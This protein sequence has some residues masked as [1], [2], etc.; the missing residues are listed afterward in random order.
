MNLRR[1]NTLILSFKE[2]HT[3]AELTNMN[4]SLRLY[5][6]CFDCNIQRNKCK[7]TQVY[8]WHSTSYLPVSLW[9]GTNKTSMAPSLSLTQPQCEPTTLPLPQQACS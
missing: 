5:Q 3:K 1:S 6:F 9:R 7:V 2:K 8:G 4:N